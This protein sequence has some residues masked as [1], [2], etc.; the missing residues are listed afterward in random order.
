[1][2]IPS[3]SIRHTGHQAQD[4]QPG[5]IPRLRV[6]GEGVGDAE[7]DRHDGSLGMENGV[8]TQVPLVQARISFALRIMLQSPWPRSGLCSPDTLT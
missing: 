5:G 1:M 2:L 8:R 3:S 4:V 6:D 7:I